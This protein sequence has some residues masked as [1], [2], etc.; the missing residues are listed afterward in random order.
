MS[1]LSEHHLRRLGTAALAGPLITSLLLFGCAKGTPR[2][3]IVVIDPVVGAVQGDSAA[4]Y[5]S[6]ENNGTDDVLLGA[7]C[8]CS[9]SVS[10]HVTEDRDGILLMVAKDHLDLPSGETTVLDPGRSHLMLEDLDA[11]LE[12]GSSISVTL[13]FEHGS[14]RTTEVPVVPLDELAERVH[15]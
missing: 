7:S 5:L 6:L 3:G 9:A 14:E 8:D 13:E 11:P 2:D 10:L 15:E 12:V 1:A 4:V